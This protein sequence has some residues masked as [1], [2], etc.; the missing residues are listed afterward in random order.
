MNRSLKFSLIVTGVI[1]LSVIIFRI[2]FSLYYNPYE[3][4]INYKNIS[5]G[6]VS[7]EIPSFWEKK[8]SDDS[9]SYYYVDWK[10]NFV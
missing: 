4:E 9:H 3:Q 7:L 10:G 8:W 6:E 5:I 1:V 2:L